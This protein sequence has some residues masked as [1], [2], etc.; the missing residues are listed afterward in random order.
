MCG[1]PA[2]KVTKPLISRRRYHPRRGRGRAC[3]R[4]EPSYMGAAP[5]VRA[6]ALFLKHTD[7]GVG[8]GAFCGRW[9]TAD[10][11]EGA[12]RGT[13]PFGGLPP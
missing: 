1:T 7:K 8:A 4:G 11:G 2:P 9:D 12:V 5:V 3:S 10:E 13:G 6:L